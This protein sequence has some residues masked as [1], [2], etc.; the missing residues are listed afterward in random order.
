[1]GKSSTIQELTG[2]DMEQGNSLYK[3][4]LKASSLPFKEKIKH[5]PSLCRFRRDRVLR[6]LM[7]N[8]MKSLTIRIERAA[9][10]QKDE[11]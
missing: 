4:Y 8:E 3:R 1:M 6:R 7:Q 10:E 2:S 9:S 11:N 5:R